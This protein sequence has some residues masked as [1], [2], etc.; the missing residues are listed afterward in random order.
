ML[1]FHVMQDDKNPGPS[2]ELDPKAQSLLQIYEGQV[3]VDYVL[4]NP[5]LKR[6]REVQSHISEQ[7]RQGFET[8]PGIRKNHPVRN[9]EALKYEYIQD[10]F[11]EIT[12]TVK[13]HEST[14]W[15]RRNL[16][17]PMTGTGVYRLN[18]FLSWHTGEWTLGNPSAISGDATFLFRAVTGDPA[19]LEMAYDVAMR[20]QDLGMG[21]MVN[22]IE[23][24][25]ADGICDISYDT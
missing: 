8:G 22:D 13:L 24:P 6:F 4:E 17:K 16:Q 21:M 23:E 5:S 20:A 12:H 1:T 19:P 9:H 2:G 10:Q 3:I 18:R 15:A 25:D 14:M 7:I 11:T